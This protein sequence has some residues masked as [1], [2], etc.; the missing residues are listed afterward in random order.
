MSA[1]Y[2]AKAIK[3]LG[4]GRGGLTD[5]TPIFYLY[6]DLYDIKCL[7]GIA[8]QEYVT[9]QY[10][11]NFKD[12]KDAIIKNYDLKNKKFNKRNPLLFKAKY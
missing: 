2:G 5:G 7:K 6:C 11:N 4:V 1:R 8:N 3:L 10:L 9:E 12:S